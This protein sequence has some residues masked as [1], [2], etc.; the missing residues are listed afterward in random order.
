MTDPGHQIDSFMVLDPDDGEEC[1]VGV[2]AIAGE[3]VVALSRR[4]GADVE[5]ALGPAQ[6]RRLAEALLAA[7]GLARD[8]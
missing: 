3:V 5:V 8:G 2:R 4:T 6:A 1:W 7:S